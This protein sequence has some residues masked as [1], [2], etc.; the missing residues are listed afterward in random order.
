MGIVI[1]DKYRGNGYSYKALF[2]L[3]K[4][5]FE[6]NKINELSDFIPKERIGA[7]KSFEKAGFIMTGKENIRK[8]I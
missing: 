4:V 2:E 3:E 5:A 7:I 8:S 1:Q 6:K